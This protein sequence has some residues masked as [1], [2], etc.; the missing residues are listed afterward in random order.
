MRKI[1]L[2][3]LCVGLLLACTVS[4]SALGTGAAE[5]QGPDPYAAQNAQQAAEKD[6]AAMQEWLQALRSRAVVDHEVPFTRSIQIVGNYC[7]PNSAYVTIRNWGKT[8]ASTTA[9]L[10]FFDGCSS[11]PS[12]CPNPGVPHTCVATYSSPQITLANYMNMP[13][14]GADMIMLR[15]TVN[16]YIGQNYYVYGVVP[17]T[18]TGETQLAS[19][20][21]GTL[22]DGYTLIAW[23]I[24]NQLKH[25]GGG[26]GFDGGHYIVLYG[27]NAGTEKVK[28]TDGNYDSRYS[29]EYIEDM[30]QLLGAMQRSNGAA[31]LLW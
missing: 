5:T 3:V 27:F 29:G 21:N 12:T 2:S 22:G 31:N 14:G 11:N 8:V 1:L 20:L 9:Q 25:Y 10:P 7:G 28:I 19:R 24:P 30:S 18:S 26:S 17:E 4:A 15:D 16:H 6:R 13:S 23:V